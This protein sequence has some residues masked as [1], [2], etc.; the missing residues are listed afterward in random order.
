MAL[1]HHPWAFAFG[2]LG[3]VISFLVFIAPLPTFWR[4]YKKKS[5]EGFQSLPYVCAIFSSMLWIYYALLKSNALLLITINSFGC[6]IETFYIAIFL[7][8]APKQ[9]K[10]AT[11]KLLVLMNLI[12][13]S[14]ILVVCSYVA[15]EAIRVQLLGWICVAFSIVVFAAPLNIIRMVIRTKSVEYMPFPLSLTLTISAVL[16]FM[17]GLLQRDL[18]IV[19]PNVLGFSFGVAQMVVYGIYRNHSKVKPTID[20]EMKVSEKETPVATSNAEQVRPVFAPEEAAVMVAVVE[21][22]ENDGIDIDGEDIEA[23]GLRESHVNPPTSCG[24]NEIKMVG[25][26]PAGAGVGGVPLVNCVV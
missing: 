17:Y 13:F 10:M 7:A 8:Y 3:N 24:A 16:W 1:V 5:T 25:S 23:H 2:I 4:I 12:G 18:Y 11:F 22:K 9:A 6:V 21:K 14:L 15:R 20:L 26:I 19:I